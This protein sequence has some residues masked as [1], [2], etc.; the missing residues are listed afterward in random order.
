[1]SQ[2]KSSIL[3]NAT[4][5]PMV[6]PNNTKYTDLGKMN[7]HHFISEK[8][9]GNI[10][11]GANT[12]TGK[13]DVYIF[14]RCSLSEYASIFTTGHEEGHAMHI[15]GNLKGLYTEAKNEGL[16]FDFLTEEDALHYDKLAHENIAMDNTG[17]LSHAMLENSPKENIAHIGGLVALIK[18]G[19][20]RE[21][22]SS[23]G[24][25]FMGEENV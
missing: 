5:I 20:E 6:L 19:V 14:T 10:V 17:A 23:M 16:F 9:D 25:W 21:I 13:F 12:Q 3:F 8:V 22:V 18:A 11:Y 2:E 1:M 24:S 4:Q 7:D 15:L